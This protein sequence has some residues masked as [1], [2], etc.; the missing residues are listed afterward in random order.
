MSDVVLW[1]MM[2]YELWYNYAQPSNHDERALASDVID[3]LVMEL[4]DV[5]GDVLMSCV[6]VCFIVQ[7]SGGGW[8]DTTYI[9]FLHRSWWTCAFTIAVLF[10]FDVA[11]VLGCFRM[12]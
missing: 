4:V 7:Y 2:W 8:V 3:G 10:W 9:T 1:M 5:L 12:W 6:L 11:I